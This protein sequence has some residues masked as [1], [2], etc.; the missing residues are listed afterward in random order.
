M[1]TPKPEEVYEAYC[2]ALEHGAYADV[3]K[4]TRYLRPLVV[5]SDL[6]FALK[7]KFR[8]LS[9][10]NFHKILTD[11]CVNRQNWEG[12]YC[13]LQRGT[14]TGVM[15]EKAKERRLLHPSGWKFLIMKRRDEE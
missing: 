12:F 9:I 5:I 8:R 3:Y 15:T 11:M 6:Y 1:K 4:Q 10:K 14:I 2:Y 13:S 7:R